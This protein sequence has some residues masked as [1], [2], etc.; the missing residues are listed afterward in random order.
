MVG[1]EEKQRVFLK[2]LHTTIV[3][4][5]Q[6]PRLIFVVQFTPNTCMLWISSVFRHVLIEG[7]TYPC[8]IFPAMQA[9]G[10]AELIEHHVDN[11]PGLR[12]LSAHSTRLTEH[13]GAG[14]TVHSA[15]CRVLESNKFH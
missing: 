8:E 13:P 3:H 5:Q 10:L 11:S 6:K 15:H 9:R 12:P 2:A 1:S 14:Q 7:F 4:T